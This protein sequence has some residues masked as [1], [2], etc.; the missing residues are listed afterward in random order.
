M[1]T[2]IHCFSEEISAKFLEILENTPE[3]EKQELIDEAVQ[4]AVKGCWMYVITELLKS[5]IVIPLESYRPAVKKDIE[6][7]FCEIDKH[8]PFDYAELKAMAVEEGA[9]EIAEWCDF[10]QSRMPS[11]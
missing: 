1:N 4:M 10:A 6:E 3:E 11:L 7:F 5:G 8:Y 2:A 9:A